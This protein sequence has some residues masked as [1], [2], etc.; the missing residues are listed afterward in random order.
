MKTIKLSIM[1]GT[2]KK[3]LA[4]FL[5]SGLRAQQSVDAVIEQQHAAD[6]ATIKSRLDAEIAETRAELERWLERIPES[7]ASSTNIALLE[8]A[9]DRY[10]ELFGEPDAFLLIE[11]AFRRVAKKARPTLQ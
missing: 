5:E 3:T 6:S 4:R 9:F 10:L 11:S 2:G 1:G 7:R 8:A